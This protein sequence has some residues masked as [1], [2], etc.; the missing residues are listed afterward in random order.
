MT[1]KILYEQ[2]SD[3][4]THFILRPLHLDS[5]Y[6][7]IDSHTQLH[8]D[9]PIFTKPNYH[10]LPNISELRLR[11]FPSDIFGRA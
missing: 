5:E 4:G 6:L 9:S 2:A 3:K 11:F 7:S 10:R 8:T 1:F